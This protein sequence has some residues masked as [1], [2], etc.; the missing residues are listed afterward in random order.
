MEYLFSYG[1]LQYD[2]VQ[3]ETFGRKLNGQPDSLS[4]Y[5]LEQLKIDNPTVV[6]ASGEAIHPIACFT[7]SQQDKISGVVFEVSAEEL[8]E[9]DKYE[10]DAYKKVALH[11]DSGLTAWVYIAYENTKNLDCWGRG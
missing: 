6:E 9:A 1:T 7:G 10:V 5:K 11:L 4:G 8:E 2:A 3:L